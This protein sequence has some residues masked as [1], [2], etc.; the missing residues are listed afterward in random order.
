MTHDLSRRALT[1]GLA[2]SA[3][4]PAAAHAQANRQPDD[5]TYSQDEIIAAGQR[6]FGTGAAGLA[7]VVERVFEDLGRPTGYIQGDEGSG[8][9][10]VGLRYGRGQL[11]L[12]NRAGTTRIYWQ[13][14]SIGLDTG[15]NAAKVFTLCYNLMTPEQIFERYG[16]VEGSAYFVGGVGVNYQ[17]RDDVTLAPMRL[18]V[19]LRLGASV[20]YL[21]Y[22][23]RRRVVPF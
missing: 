17:R 2:A 3:L 15:G 10:G 22:T 23:R 19:G 20:G 16:G 8:A 4:V 14:P 18:G 1:L 7:T 12:K 6:F 13:G 11:R 9:A 5:N 21:H